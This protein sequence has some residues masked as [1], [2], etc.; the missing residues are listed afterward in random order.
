M[1]TAKR[2]TMFEWIF[3]PD[4]FGDRILHVGFGGFILAAILKDAIKQ[5]TPSTEVT[6]FVCFSFALLL[7][8]PAVIGKTPPKD[9]TLRWPILALATAY[10]WMSLLYFFNWTQLVKLAAGYDAVTDLIGTLFFVVAWFMISVREADKQ[11][12][13]ADRFALVILCLLALASGASKL[14]IDSAIGGSAADGAAARLFL[15]VCNGA[16]FL[17]LYGQMRRLLPPPDPVTH[18]LIL[19]YGCAQIAAHGRDCLSASKPCSPPA[20]ESF[21]ALAIAWT[22]LL[23]KVAFGAYV[24]YLYFNGR[25]GDPV[26][27]LK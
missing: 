17:S 18:T 13:V 19:L 4:S 23:G 25:I 12:Q 9:P 10:A 26:N 7:A 21:V 24:S 22:L 14:L 3:K 20:L 8:L 27:K 5:L 15:N 11:S 16:V 2:P 6:S 1:T